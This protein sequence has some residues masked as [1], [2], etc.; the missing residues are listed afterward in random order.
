[1]PGRQ[2][3]YDLRAEKRPRELKRH[4]HRLLQKYFAFFVPPRQRVLDLGCG[5]G[6]LL[7]AVDPEKAL[8][9]DFSPKTIDLA[10]HL[11]PP[12]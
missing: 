2:N 1:V 6:D 4:Y 7:A 5:L 3:F 11:H 10:R 8:G 12:V 9:V